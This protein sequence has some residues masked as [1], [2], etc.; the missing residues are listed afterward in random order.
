M[1]IANEVLDSVR[2]DPNLLQ[3]VITGDEAWVYGYDVETK[4]QSSQWK[5]PHEPRPKKARQ[6]RSNVKVLL[7]VFFDCRGVVHHEFLSQ[8]R[9]T[10]EEFLSST[11]PIPVEDIENNRKVIEETHSELLVTQG[12]IRDFMLTSDVSEEELEH[13]DVEA[14]EYTFRYKT[15]YKK[16][17]ELVKPKVAASSSTTS[18]VS[19]TSSSHHRIKTSQ[20]LGL[21]PIGQESV[22]HV[23]FGGHTSESVNQEY[24]V[25]LGHASG[26]FKMVAKPLDQ[27]NICGNL[28]RLSRGPWMKELKAR[29]IWVPDIGK[30]DKEIEIFLGCDVLGFIFMMKSCMMSNDLTASQTRFVWTSMGECQQGSDVSLAHHVTTMTISE[31]SITNL[32][33]LDVLGIMNL[34]VKQRDQRDAL[35]RR[36]F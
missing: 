35:S 29:R 3:R 22:K 17:L 18:E 32:W 27:Q 26:N 2:D 25:T 34:E 24:R 30:D 13:D 31:S 33:N 23:V 21:S 19:F 9:T 6:V 4:A 11:P 16:C 7:T 1:N 14:M 15:I 28:P 12:K 10:T 8:G 5:L 36:Y 20:D